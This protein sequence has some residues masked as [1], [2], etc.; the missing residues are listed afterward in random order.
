MN[1]VLFIL[2]KIVSASMIYDIFQ[3]Y[4]FI[5]QSRI[6]ILISNNLKRNTDGKL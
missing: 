5:F 2:I 6:E 1:K 4:T 3:R